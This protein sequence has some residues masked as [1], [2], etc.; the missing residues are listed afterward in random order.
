LKIILL[1][2]SLGLDLSPLSRETLPL[3]AEVGKL[4]LGGGL[5]PTRLLE[6]LLDLGE[7]YSPGR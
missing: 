7:F 4:R 3:G 6:T 5:L 1:P 2:G